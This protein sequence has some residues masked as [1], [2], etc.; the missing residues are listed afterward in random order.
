MTESEKKD[1]LK[2]WI[3]DMDECSMDS[4]IDEYIGSPSQDIDDQESK[5]QT[6]KRTREQLE[7]YVREFIMAEMPRV[8]AL[9]SGVS[10]NLIQYIADVLEDF[11]DDI[12]NV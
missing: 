3:D 2:S 10:L 4:L 7:Q 11:Q 6:K 1:F 12:A 9:G 8:K 5:T